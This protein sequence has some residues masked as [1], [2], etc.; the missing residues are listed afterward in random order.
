MFL[1]DD[2][3]VKEIDSPN[4]LIY[5]PILSLYVRS[6]NVRSRSKEPDVKSDYQDFNRIE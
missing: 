3:T 4:Y 2:L 6:S 5:K 1:F